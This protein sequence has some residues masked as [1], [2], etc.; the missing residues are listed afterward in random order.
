MIP[1]TTTSPES[2]PRATL[3]S[4]KNNKNDRVA[5]PCPVK[6]SEM[7]ARSSESIAVTSARMVVFR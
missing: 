1:P 5:T 4:D 3:R 6:D 7:I 2:E